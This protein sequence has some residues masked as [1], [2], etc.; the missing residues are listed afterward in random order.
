MMQACTLRGL[1]R[2]E[3]VAHPTT[4]SS[5]LLFDTVLFLYILWSIRSRSPDFRSE[6]AVREDEEFGSETNDV[7]GSFCFMGAK[8]P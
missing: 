3:S 1:S 8:L 6:I 5:T 7:S 2:T 4:V